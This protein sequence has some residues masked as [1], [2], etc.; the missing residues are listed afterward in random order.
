MPM[1]VDKSAIL[2]RLNYV[3]QQWRATLQTPNVDLR[4]LEKGINQLAAT[5][6]Q[7]APPKSVYIKRMND[8]L[9]HEIGGNQLEVLKVKGNQLLGQLEALTEAYSANQLQS[10]REMIHA[11]MFSDFLEMAEYLLEEGY[12]HPAAVIAGSVLEEHLRKLCARFGVALPAKPKLDAMNADLARANAYDKNNAKQVTAWAGI[13]NDAAHGHY[14]N[15][16]PEQVKLMVA[17]IRDFMI[18][19]P[20]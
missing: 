11:D 12:H 20:A 14:A 10:V 15:Y 16:T 4:M 9:D 6:D 17:G 5:I 3:R 7:Y 8:V 13:R 18:R 1:P 2:S 19:N